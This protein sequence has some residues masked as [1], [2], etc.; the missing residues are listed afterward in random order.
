MATRPEMTDRFF[1]LSLGNSRVVLDVEVGHLR[2]L[3]LAMGERVIAPL[4]VAPWVNDAPI[5]SASA[6]APAEQALAGDFLCAP[7]CA[8]DME[9]APIHGWVANAPWTPVVTDAAETEVEARFVLSRPVLGAE[10]V[11]TLRFRAGEPFL[12]QSH[13]FTGGRGRLPVSHHAM[14]RAAGQAALSFSPKA[15]A[16]TGEPLETD[17]AMG[18]SV[19]LY[20]SESTDLAAIPLADG[21]T[22]DIHTYPFAERHEDV[23]ALIEGAGSAFGW[24]AAVRDAEDDIVLLVKDARQLPQTLLWM[25]N[26]GR[27]YPPWNGRHTRVL[28]LEDGRAYGSTGHRASI[29]PNPL[30]GR[31]VPTA[32]DLG[33]NPVIRYAVGAIP[34]PAG[35]TRVAGVAAGADGLTLTD[36]SGATLTVPFDTGWLPQ[37]A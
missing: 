23:V 17:P 10:V 34:R 20:P 24:T 26:G 12:Y 2:A 16:F 7:F 14:I 33:D 19:L 28:G 5:D 18:R 32:F 3:E 15:L 9:P 36:V 27:F 25:S 31:G 6:T 35:W 21:G 22:V 8:S 1:A 30:A 4:H 11:K 29:E 13:A 37:S